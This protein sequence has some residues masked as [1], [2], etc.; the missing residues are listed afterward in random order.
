MNRPTPGHTAG[1][2]GGL[3]SAPLGRRA[4]AEALGTWMLLVGVVGS[5]IAAGRLTD[6]SAVALLVNALAT[7]GVLV[8]AIVAL[9]GVSGAHLNP[10]VSLLAAARGALGVRDLVAYTTAQAGGA[11]AGVVTAHLMFDLPP[12][13]VEGAARGGAHLVLSEVVAT[14][15]L[16]VV[17][18]GAARTGR[19]GTVAAVVGGWIGA[20]YFCT[21][22]T[23][24]ANPAVT[25][26]RSLTGTFTGIRAADVPAFVGAELVAVPL[27]VICLTVLGW[28]RPPVV[29][30]GGEPGQPAAPGRRLRTAT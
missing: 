6:D 27:A 29:T 19:S 1:S 7:V 14:V 20:A 21:S 15:V 26:A 10:A 30:P 12:V 18:E 28:R 4:A 3:A 23:S 13:A 11:V 17:I 24:F 2:P 9:A 22:S 25:V 16:L 5:G 8:A